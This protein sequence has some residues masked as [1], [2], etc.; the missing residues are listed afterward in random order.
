MYVILR[1]TVNIDRGNRQGLYR[2]I[3]IIGIG[4]IAKNDFPIMIQITTLI[5]I[6]NQGCSKVSPFGVKDFGGEY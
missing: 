4:A 6:D 5:R 2:S 1:P 3:V